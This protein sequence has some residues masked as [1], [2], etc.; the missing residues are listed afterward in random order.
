MCST[1]FLIKWFLIKKHVLVEFI[2]CTKKGK[3]K[4]GKKSQSTK[5]VKNFV[6]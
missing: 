1:K 6:R 2:K 4:I 5:T 3:E